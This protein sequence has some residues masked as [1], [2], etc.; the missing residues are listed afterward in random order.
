MFK[1]PPAQIRVIKRESHAPTRRGGQTPEDTFAHPSGQ[2]DNLRPSHRVRR[3]SGI[4]SAVPVVSWCVPGGVKFRCTREGGMGRGTH[5]ARAFRRRVDIV[6]LVVT[7]AGHRRRGD[8]NFG[9][10]LP[11][12]PPPVI[13]RRI[14]PSY[15]RRCGVRSVAPHRPSS[16]STGH[17]QKGPRQRYQQRQKRR[18]WQERWRQR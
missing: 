9:S 13:T 4:A 2:D 8:F 5:R 15:L 6:L 11:P 18:W 1:N 10:G 14:A 7:A 3:A 17:R 16:T 12:P